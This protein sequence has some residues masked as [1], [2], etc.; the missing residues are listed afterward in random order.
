MHLFLFGKYKSRHKMPR[1][2]STVYSFKHKLSN[3][4]LKFIPIRVE[5]SQNHLTPVNDVFVAKTTEFYLQ[6]FFYIIAY[7]ENQKKKHNL[8]LTLLNN[9]R[10]THL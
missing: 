9:L 1:L 5:L 4:T 2:K 8:S 6:S 7:T 10:I 3:Q